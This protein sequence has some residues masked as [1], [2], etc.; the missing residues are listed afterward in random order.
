MENLKLKEKSGETN[1]PRRRDLAYV[2]KRNN[3][4]L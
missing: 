3:A 4:C 1:Y 2:E